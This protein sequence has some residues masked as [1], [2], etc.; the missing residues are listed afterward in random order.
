MSEFISRGQV[1]QDRFVWNIL[2]HKTDGFFLDI[3][4]GHPVSY[5]NSYALEQM[6]WTGI[7]CDLHLPDLD[8]PRTARR[9]EGDARLILWKNFLP[10]R[11]D[12]LSLDTDEL[13]GEVLF[14]LLQSDSRFSVITIEHDYYLRGPQ[15]MKQE[16]DLLT[17]AGYELVCAKVLWEGHPFEDWWVDPKVISPETAS[18]FKCI[19]VE[20][21]IAAK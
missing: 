5:S 11:V 15:L 21:S 13:S 8:I 7:L 18:R 14:S 20:G 19:H 4:A 10:L 9:V 12:Y 6:G 1:A 2:G 3:G 17:R 16:R